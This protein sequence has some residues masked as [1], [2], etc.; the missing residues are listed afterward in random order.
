M[1]LKRKANAKSDKLSPGE[2]EEDLFGDLPDLEIGMESERVNDVSSNPEPKEDDGKKAKRRRKQKAVASEAPCETSASSSSASTAASKKSKKDQL[3][4]DFMITQLPALRK[5]IKLRKK[6]ETSFN[7]RD[8]PQYF[9][10]GSEF[11]PTYCLALFNFLGKNEI[12]CTQYG[13]FQ[14]SR[15]M[16]KTI[17][18]FNHGNLIIS[19]LGTSDALTAD[20]IEHMM[21]RFGREWFKIP[22]KDAPRVSSAYRYGD[23]HHFKV[24]LTGIYEDSFFEDDGNEVKTANPVL[25]YEPLRAPP[26]KTKSKAKT[27]EETVDQAEVNKS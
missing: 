11:V 19:S 23:C 7:V 13:V 4:E 22:A 20:E 5:E 1:S 9:K 24:I 27:A 12:T 25:R 10:P 8:F 18:G 6:G 26:V 21:K 16:V 14:G 2:K 17:D 3:I 15:H